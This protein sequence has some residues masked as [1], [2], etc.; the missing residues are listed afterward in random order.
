MD[1]SRK[2]P[3]LLSTSVSYKQQ[4]HYSYIHQILYIPLEK[5]KSWLIP[6]QKSGDDSSIGPIGPTDY[7]LLGGELPTNRLGGL[8]HP[9][10]KDMGF[11]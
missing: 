1:H 10:E 2:I 8:V 9:S 5:L 3:Y 6:I 11:L 4:H 7:S